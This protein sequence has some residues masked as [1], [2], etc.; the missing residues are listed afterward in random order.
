MPPATDLRQSL[1]EMD[2]EALMRLVQK[3]DRRGWRILHARYEGALK[4]HLRK[5]FGLSE[6]RAEDLVQETFLRVFRHAYRY[7]PDRQFSSWIYSIAANL[8][9]NRLRDRS[10]MADDLNYADLMPESPGVEEDRGPEE[11]HYFADE[12]RGP[13]RLADGRKVERL[14]REAVEELSPARRV[15]LLLRVD[16]G[17]SYQE[18]GE[19]TGVPTGTVK[20]RLAR[21]RQRVREHLREEAPEVL[22]RIFVEE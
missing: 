17:L 2:D 16:K 11:E 6:Q 18:I 10:R 7:D 13:T 1:E 21:A 3:G 15:S 9:K 14:F 22:S 19:A 4:N 5:T 12:S 20:S 8:G